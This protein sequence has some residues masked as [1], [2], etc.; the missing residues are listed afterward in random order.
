MAL[1]NAKRTL[2]DAKRTLKTCISESASE[3]CF[4]L[5]VS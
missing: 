3:D 4:F 5:A 1:K 2:K